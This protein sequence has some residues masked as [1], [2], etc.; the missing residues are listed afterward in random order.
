MDNKVRFVFESGDNYGEDVACYNCGKP[1]RES[2]EGEVKVGDSVVCTGCGG[3]LA[4]IV[5]IK[6]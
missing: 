4:Y 1:F 2:V 3:R 5:D 6:K